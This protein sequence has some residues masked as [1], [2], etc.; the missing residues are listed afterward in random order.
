MPQTTMDGVWEGVPLYWRRVAKMT[1]F[2]A[3]LLPFSTLVKIFYT[4]DIDN[5]PSLLWLRP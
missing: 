5:H 4:Y 1:R 3:R 2:G